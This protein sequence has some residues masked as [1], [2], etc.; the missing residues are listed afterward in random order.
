MDENT[1]EPN[2]FDNTDE[3][4]DLG[5]NALHSSEPQ[6]T[7]ISENLEALNA[8]ENPKRQE[9][10]SAAQGPNEPQVGESDEEF[11]ANSKD[12]LSQLHHAAI[13]ACKKTV[14]YAIK[15]GETLIATKERVKH[16][17]WEKWVDANLPFSSK[18]AYNYMRL[19]KN[20]KAV[21]AKYETVSDLGVT[22]TYRALARFPKDKETEKKVMPLHVPNPPQVTADADQPS[23]N[24]PSNDIGAESD[25]NEEL[26]VGVFH[27]TLAL[28]VLEF[29]RE[30]DVDQQNFQILRGQGQIAKLKP[31]LFGKLAPYLPK[32]DIQDPAS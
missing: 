2:E 1:S 7:P 5:E 14:H 12:L 30:L 25:E 23:S 13:G 16:G 26:V 27:T 10:S 6:E 24:P 18:T 11:L 22:E 31:I 9:E 29:I 19:A 4:E 17:N 20:Q 32:P 15:I 28:K 8:S 3:A 21:L